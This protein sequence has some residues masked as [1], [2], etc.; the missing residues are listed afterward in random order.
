MK[1][2]N[3]N[4][5]Q[6]T[7]T[8]ELGTF[9]NEEILI[10]LRTN[11]RW[12]VNDIN[13]LI[14]ILINNP[15]IKMKEDKGNTKVGEFR[16]KFYD[17]AVAEVIMKID[18]GRVVRVSDITKLSIHDMIIYNFE[19]GNK[20]N[21]IYNERG[22]KRNTL[23]QHVQDLVSN[24]KYYNPEYFNKDIPA[25]VQMSLRKSVNLGGYYI[26]DCTFNHIYE[27]VIGLDINK[28]YPAICTNKRLPYGVPKGYVGYEIPKENEVAFYMVIIE[29]KG[30]FK[31]GIAPLINNLYGVVM[32]TDLEFDYLMEYGEGWEG[33]VTYTYIYQT[34]YLFGNYFTDKIEEL[35]ALKSAGDLDPVLEHIIKLE[36]NMVTGTMGKRYNYQYGDKYGNPI[37]NRTAYW[38][39]V[40][41]GRIELMKAINILGYEN[42]VYSDTDSIYTILSM[43]EI[44]ER[45]GQYMHPMIMGHFK[46]EHI[47]SKFFVV[48]RKVYYGIENGEWS[49]THA[50][51]KYEDQQ[52]E[53]EFLEKYGPEKFIERRSEFVQPYRT[54]IEDFIEQLKNGNIEWDD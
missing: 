6:D 17:K 14:R 40:I 21:N 51:V 33:I 2:L 35:Y 47:F 34:A 54:S 22:Y 46:I 49:V 16:L 31:K 38:Y 50:G 52:K 10:Q 11:R 27:N 29:K 8:T 20:L 18:R 23:S 28:S 15:D 48:Q 25:I 41:L 30:T 12:R 45:L 44:K 13:E 24:S 42:C 39:M 43:E 26:K 19:I 1:Y 32:L 7:F 37:A 53:K 9:P 4:L 5:G 3:I 36:Y